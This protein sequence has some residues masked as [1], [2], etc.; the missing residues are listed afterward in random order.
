M[1]EFTV[2]L[3]TVSDVYIVCPY[4]GHKHWANNDDIG[5]D[6]EERIRDCVQ[7]GSDFH[8]TTRIKHTFESKRLIDVC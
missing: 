6:Y 4:C 1:P 8:Y 7:C 5:D 3:E 2:E